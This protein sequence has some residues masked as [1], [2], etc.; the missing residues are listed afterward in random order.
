MS[1]S[2]KT[3]F[4]IVLCIAVLLSAGSIPFAAYVTKSA[5]DGGRGGALAVALSFAVLF[6][7]RGYGTKVYDVLTKE[8]QAVNTNLQKI[9]GAAGGG[10]LTSDQKIDA[11]VSKT[12]IDADVQHN[13][14]VYLAWSS[15]I[16]TIA[17]GFGD[18]AAQWLIGAPAVVPCCA[19]C[20][21]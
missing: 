2:T 3:R 4:V 8:A 9:R 1:L 13:Q 19:A 17:W 5:Q 11:L 10:A 12:T 18:I 15:G 21:G 6:L 20:T 7:S 16:G 14:N